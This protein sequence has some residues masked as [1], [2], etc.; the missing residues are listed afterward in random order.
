MLLAPFAA[1]NHSKRAHSKIEEV[2]IK[3]EPVVLQ[4][5]DIY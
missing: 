4:M 2:N 3:S 1:C 5:A